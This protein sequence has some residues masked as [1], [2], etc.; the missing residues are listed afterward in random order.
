M[1]PAWSVTRTC[2]RVSGPVILVAAWVIAVGHA[3]SDQATNRC[4]GPEIAIV[5]MVV[6]TIMM[7]TM[8]MVTTSMVVPM[9]TTSMVA[10]S[11]VAASVMA[12][13]VMAASVMAVAVCLRH[14]SALNETK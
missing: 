9:V 12:S 13:A 10:A 11:G 8:V 7:A 14:V 1:R 4:T 6:V 3:I 5:V 2:A